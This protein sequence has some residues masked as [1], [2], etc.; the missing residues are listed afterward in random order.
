VN[1]VTT[2]TLH[3]AAGHAAAA[4][5]AA[6][7][8]PNDIL[9]AAN[10]VLAFAALVTAVVGVL[11][12]VS[13][14]RVVEH[15]A[16]QAEASADQARE[17][18]KLAVSAGAQAKAM[19]ESAQATKEAVEAALDQ[20]A[21]AQGSLEVESQALLASMRPVVVEVPLGLFTHQIER[22]SYV[23][24]IDD[25]AVSRSFND[26]GSVLVG[27]PIRNIGP[28]PAFVRDAKLSPNPG[29]VFDASV[30]HLVIPSGERAIIWC[31][32][33]EHTIGF[34]ALKLGLQ[35][36][37]VK[38]MVRY[39]DVGGTQRTQSMMQFRFAPEEAA[40]DY[41][42]GSVEKLELY[43]CDDHWAP[44]NVPFNPTD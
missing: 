2:T 13:S 24:N 25:G 5:T 40:A 22:L 35:S 39:S 16:A 12:I 41:A 1:T 34:S 10:I 29:M 28:G 21:L 44:S 9:L 26:D 33:T 7:S 15:A 43:G 23:T 18:G 38:A 19:D 32:A 42:T 27:I 14:N 11:A 6:S 36:G 4:Q 20:V 17:S 3:V 30:D 37:S 8:G 31:E